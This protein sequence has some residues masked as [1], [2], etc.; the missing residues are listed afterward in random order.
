VK[1]YLRDDN[2]AY[3][4]PHCIPKA[5]NTHLEYVILDDLIYLLTA[6]ALTSGGN[7]TVHIYTHCAQNNTLKQ[8][9]QNR[10]YIH[11]YIHNK[12]T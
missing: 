1:K 8:N 11:T 6:I 9:L 3:A 4:F 10:T 5:T 12:N 7:S 2:M